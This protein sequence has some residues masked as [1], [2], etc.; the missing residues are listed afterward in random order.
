MMSK[1]I[2]ETL[3]KSS[4]KHC[5]HKWEKYFVC[6][7]FSLDRCP[8]CE[9]IKTVNKLK[10]LKQY[11]DT[12]IEEAVKQF[13]IRGDE[14][15]RFAK[16]FIDFLPE[17]KGTLLDIGCGLGWYVA[18]ANV[19][20]HKAIGIDPNKGMI[21]YGKKRVE[22]NL[23]AAS[24]ETFTSKQKFDY[25]TLCHVIEHIPDLPA[26]LSK[27]KTLLKHNGL[28]LIA[29]PNIDSLMF[30]IFKCRWYPMLPT[31]HVWQFTPKALKRILEDEGFKIKKTTITNMDY[32]PKN[33]LK[34]FAFDTANTFANLIE[35]GD[36]LV[37][38]ATKNE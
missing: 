19:R 21:S 22:P 5:Q 34:K 14:Y 38:L 18:E 16:I 26:L 20:G 2:P 4:N 3:K 6:D 13:W 37:I 36:Q 25:V 7:S 29:T 12:D 27:I 10:S 24:Y 15:R 31:E 23:F 33:K 28:V 35:K 32:S 1:D 8:K 9:L 17:K 30:K 11:S